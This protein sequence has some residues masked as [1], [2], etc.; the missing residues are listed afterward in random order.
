M[1]AHAAHMQCAGTLHRHAHT[2]QTHCTDALHRRTAQ[3]GTRAAAHMI[4]KHTF[5]LPS[6]AIACAEK[7]LET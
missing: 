5:V 7:S 3:H 2:A 6:K 1:H 4:M